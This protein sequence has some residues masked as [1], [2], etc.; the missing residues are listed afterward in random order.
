MY[1]TPSEKSLE[2]LF[3]KAINGCNGNTKSIY[4]LVKLIKIEMLLGII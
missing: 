1:R 4:T 3:K 2:M